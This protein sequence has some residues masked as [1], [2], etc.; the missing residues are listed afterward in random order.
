MSVLLNP[1][2]RVGQTIGLVVCLATANQKRR[3]APLVCTIGVS[4]EAALSHN[5]MPVLP[6]GVCCDVIELIQSLR[7]GARVLD[8]GARS[9]SF[10]T[11]RADI[12]VVRLDLEVPL[13]RKP[14]AYIRGD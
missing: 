14:G 2:I 9:G 11:G 6:E 3:A 10:D 13:S 8:L 4:G 7:P 12:P 5:A 1:G